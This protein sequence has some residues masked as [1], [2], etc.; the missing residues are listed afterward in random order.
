MSANQTRELRLTSSAAAP[1]SARHM[2]CGQPRWSCL[3]PRRPRPRPIA[4]INPPTVR[5]ITRADFYFIVPL[6]VPALPRG[7]QLNLRGELI[8]LWLNVFRQFSGL[9]IQ[10]RQGWRISGRR[11]SATFCCATAEG[12]QSSPYKCPT[13]TLPKGTVHLLYSHAFEPSK[14]PLCQDVSPNSR[15]RKARQPFA[16]LGRKCG[17]AFPAASSPSRGCSRPGAASRPQSCQVLTIGG[18]V[19]PRDARP[20]GAAS[21]SALLLA[22]QGKLA[23]PPAWADPL[24][25]ALAEPRTQGNAPAP[26]RGAMTSGAPS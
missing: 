23:S 21:L 17:F 22:R 7:T 16:T 20:V 26:D 9:S 13:H 8:A 11:R 14:C 19:V 5:R 6:S 1:K 3:R 2:P 15:F 10:V 12:E 4:R 18:A 24:S 25:S